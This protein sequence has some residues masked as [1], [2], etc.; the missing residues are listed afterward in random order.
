MKPLLMVVVVMAALIGCN[1]QEQQ[2]PKATAEKQPAAEKT[3]PAPKQ[4]A[5]DV[6]AGK[7]IAERDC[8][9]CHGLDGKGV[10]PGIP[11]LAAQREAYLLASL[12]EYKEGK[13]PHA[14]LKDMMA[15]MSDADMRNVAAYFASLPPVASQ[16]AAA[17]KGSSLYEE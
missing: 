15:N 2:T 7:A 12:K 1:Q 8:K 13:R 3:V 16:T 5:G 11:N 14:A 17:T 4:P 10:A 6:N 9:A